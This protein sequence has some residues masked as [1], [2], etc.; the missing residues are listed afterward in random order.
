LIVLVTVT[1]SLIPIF[2]CLRY[3]FLIKVSQNNIF[4]KNNY[5]KIDEQSIEG[6]NK[7]KFIKISL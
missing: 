6:I 7:H 1:K 5:D 2:A 3:K 4:V